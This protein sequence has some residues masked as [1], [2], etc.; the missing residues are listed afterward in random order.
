MDWLSLVFFV[1]SV[2]SMPLAA[3]MAR[4]RARSSRL[5]FWIAFIVGPVAPLLL[6]VLGR[7]GGEPNSAVQAHG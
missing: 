6:L 1:V 4:A 2:G 3:N 5:W 7:R